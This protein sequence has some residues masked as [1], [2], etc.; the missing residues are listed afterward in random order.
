[1]IAEVERWLVGAAGAA[2]TADDGVIAFTAEELIAGR[3]QAR[4]A[5]S[6]HEA[7]R[8]G[9]PASAHEVIVVI[10]GY[11]GKTFLPAL[12]WLVTQWLAAR[13]G[14]VQWHLDRHQGPNSVA[15]Q[16][17]SLGWDIAKERAGRLVIL[18][19]QAP[20]EAD[21]PVPREISVKVGDAGLTLAA[22]YG[23]FSPGA[24]D[25]GTA[26]LLDRALQSD[27]VEVV[28]D[29]GTGYGPLAIGLVASGIARRA[30]ATDV[31][32]IA[33]W[34][35]ERN[36][37][38]NNVP[39]RVECS[40]EPRA[41]ENTELTVC[42]IPTHL[43]AART[44]GLMAGLL[45]RAKRGRLLVVVHASLEARYARYFGAAGLRPARHAGTAHVVLDTRR[46]YSAT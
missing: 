16:L 44:Q 11:R 27:P 28:A 30:V 13:G 17:T 37:K 14:S 45:S 41:V 39:L 43:D 22:D 1:M 23:V 21:E 15:K 25:D 2:A 20:G 19:G 5:L 42:N 46:T 6:F 3:D 29:I 7:A 33:L 36:A 34:L 26:L 8:H 9:V 18:R 40:P 12:S 38:L 35:A 4:L 10:P 24:L 32:C 31:D